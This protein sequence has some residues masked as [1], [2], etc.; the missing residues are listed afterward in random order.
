M[1]LLGIFVDSGVFRIDIFKKGFRKKKKP[2]ARTYLKSKPQQWT[3]PFQIPQKSSNKNQVDKPSVLPGKPEFVEAKPTYTLP[4]PSANAET[5]TIEATDSKKS[6]KDDSARKSFLNVFKSLTHR[7]RSWD[8]WTDFVTM[9]ACAISN[10]VDEAHFDEREKTY[11]RIISK[12][13]KEEQQLFPELLACL[14]LALEENPEQDFL[15]DVYTELGLNSK[16]HQQIFTPYNAAHM[17]A[18]MIM[19]D[20]EQEV[21]KKGFMTIHDSCCGGGVTLI[22]AANVVKEKLVKMGLNYQNHMLVTGQD[23]DHVVAMMCYVQMSLLGVAGY[24]KVGNTI[25][26]PMT[27]GDSLDNYWFTPMFFSP[28]WTCRRMI[29]QLDRQIQGDGQ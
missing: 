11:L 23:I 16:E 2:I 25:T 27:V 3:P 26:E 13:S 12:Y 8:I 7:W 21:E 24:F 28:V 22:A 19:E 29:R 10:S 15:G 9:A 20:V 17:M 4:E 5:V 18:E 1:L 6:I 14:V